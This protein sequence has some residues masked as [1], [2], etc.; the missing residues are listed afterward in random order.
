MGIAKW[1]IRPAQPSYDKVFPKGP[2]AQLGA[3]I[4]GIDEVTGSIPVWSTI[5]RS[6]ELKAEA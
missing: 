5:L 2:V 4:N 6:R 1:L 3:R